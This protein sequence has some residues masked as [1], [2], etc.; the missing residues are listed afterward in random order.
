MIFAMFLL[1]AEATEVSDAVNYGGGLMGLL[2]VLGSGAILLLQ[3]RDRLKYD[4]DRIKLET[5]IQ[6]LTK[7]VAASEEEEKKCR[8]Q[9]QIIEK[10]YEEI[11]QRMDAQREKFTEAIE[12][13]RR[14]RREEVSAL[15][16]RMYQL[17]YSKSPPP[18]STPLLPPV[19][20]P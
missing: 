2:S 14:D 16:Q 13:E 18:P 19:P 8:D 5:N 12:K 7:Q 1:L 9:Y 4:G 20:P 17:Q 11:L 3:Q 10:K 15:L 6:T